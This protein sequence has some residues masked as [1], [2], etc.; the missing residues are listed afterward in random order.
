MS[1]QTTN[2]ELQALDITTRLNG[3]LILDAL[4]L[5]SL[6]SG[7]LVALLGPNGSGKSTL[8]KSLAGLVPAS[9]GALRLGSRNLAPLHASARAEYIRYLPQSLPGDIHLTV[10][11]SILVALRARSALNTQHALSIV[12]TT[13]T[14]LGIAHLANRY[15]DE[16]SGGQK[17]L[18]GLAQALS[19]E[20]QILL[21]DEPLASLDL[22]HQHHV[23]QLLGRLTQ[24]RKLLTLIVLHDLNSVLQY[25]SQALLMRD[26]ALLASGAPNKVITTESLAAM[27]SVR[28]RI[29]TCSQG[30][31]YVLVDGL[32]PI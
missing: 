17:Q 4:D 27:F 12:K 22:N 9:F 11:E 16:L 8:L 26:G 10:V 14:E 23:M 24:Q 31:P 15:L 29:E 28:A 6:G 3:R 21:L 13:L 30:R 2:G 5:P 7:Q 1:P 32:L 19:H 20:P 18:V 25:C